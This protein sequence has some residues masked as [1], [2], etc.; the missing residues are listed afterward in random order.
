VTVAILLKVIVSSY[1]GLRPMGIC[2]SNLLRS[3][4]GVVLAMLL[5]MAAVT[6]A[7]RMHTL[8]VPSTLGAGLRHYGGYA[9]WAAAQQILLQCFFLSRSLRLTSNGPLAAGVSACLFAIAHLPNPILTVITLVAGLASCLFFLRYKNLWPLA[10][11]HAILGISIA[12][13]IPGKLDHN[14]RVGISYLKYVDRTVLSE[15][16]PGATVAPTALPAKP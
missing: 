15:T 1:D 14:M 3:L 6:L 8:H 12:V 11:A 4:W 10:V 9:L 2:T 5:G 16:V 13:T 7:G